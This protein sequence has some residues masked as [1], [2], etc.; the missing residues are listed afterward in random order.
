MS[1]N[2]IHH[3]SIVHTSGECEWRAMVMMPV[4]DNSWLVYQSSLVVLQAETS[5]A[6][7][8]NGRKNEKFAYSVSLIRQLIFTCRKILRHGISGCISHPKEGVLRIFIALKNP[9][10]RPGLN[11][12][13]LGPVASTPTTTPP[14]RRIYGF[15]IIVSVKRVI[16]LNNINQLIFVMVKCGVL[17]EVRT[18]FLNYYIDELRIQR[19]NVFKRL[20]RFIADLHK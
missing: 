13:P 14:R 16:S 4:G 9:S 1:Q 18:E 17:F 20:K 5:G 2:C 10:L 6:S 3:W 8:R 19:V 15:C 11:P 7:R 12:R